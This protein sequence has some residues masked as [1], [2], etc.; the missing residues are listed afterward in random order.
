MR[1]LNAK[2]EENFFEFATERV[3]YI[4]MVGPEDPDEELGE[5]IQQ[6]SSAVE[7]KTWLEYETKI[8]FYNDQ[9]MYEAYKQG[10]ID[11]LFLFITT[12]NRYI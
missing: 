2:V 12:K 10:F 9:T 6:I 4:G 7:P 8:S 3:C 11:A 1:K 5:L